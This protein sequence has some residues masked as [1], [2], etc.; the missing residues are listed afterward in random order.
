MCSVWIPAVIGVVLGLG[1]TAVALAQDL[2][3]LPVSSCEQQVQEHYRRLSA[4]N[5][6]PQATAL[7]WGPELV[8]IVKQLRV[9]DNQYKLKQNQAEFAEQNW[10]RVLADQSMMPPP[11]PPAPAN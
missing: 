8:A 1:C 11:T 10:L 2:P 5:L 6:V 4:D 3:A 9:R 7:E